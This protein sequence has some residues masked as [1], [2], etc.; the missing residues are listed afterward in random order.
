LK[1]VLDILRYGPD[2]EVLGPK[3]LREEVK[4]KLLAALGHYQ[5]LKKSKKD[6]EDHIL[7]LSPDML[8]ERENLTR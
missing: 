8:E 2:V 4:E 6:C 1:L 5:S 7:S 3:E